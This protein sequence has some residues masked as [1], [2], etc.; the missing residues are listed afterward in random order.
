MSKGAKAWLIFIIVCIVIT[1][2]GSIIEINNKDKRKAEEK[3]KK[4]T[5]E[6]DY[7]LIKEEIFNP[8]ENDISKIAV[9]KEDTPKNLKKASYVVVRYYQEKNKPATW[10]YTPSI[11]EFDRENEKWTKEDLENIPVIVFSISKY[12]SKTYQ[13]VSGGSGTPTIRSET[14]DLYYYN[15]KTKSVFMKTTIKGKKLPKSTTSAHDYT[16]S[17]HQIERKIKQDFGRFVLPEWLENIL[18]LVLIFA[19]PAGIGVIIGIINGRKQRKK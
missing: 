11:S 12:A 14:V 19:V 4:E 13:Y 16:I 1:V 9:R 17:L 10:E 7:E 18:Y 6:S 5:L 3:L 2:A 8:E 15:T